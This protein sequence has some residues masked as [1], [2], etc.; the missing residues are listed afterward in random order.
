MGL[1]L[2]PL[3]GPHIGKLTKIM[4]RAFD[5]DTRIHLGEETGGPDGYNNGVFL[6]RWGLHKDASSYCISLNGQ[7]IGGVVLWIK[8]NNHNFL[9]NIFIDPAYENQGI[10]TKV[11]NMVEK[12]YPDTKVWETETP[13]FSSRN[14]NFYVNKCGFHI[15]KIENPKN[16]LEGQYKMQKV[17]K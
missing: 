16:R 6:R 7:L 10:G 5:E 8:E 17:M 9:G 3:E 11:W 4:E 12:L 14:H 1:E 2:I 15:I 13:I